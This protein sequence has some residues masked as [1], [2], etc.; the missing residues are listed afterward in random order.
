MKDSEKKDQS[1]QYSRVTEQKSQKDHIKSIKFKEN[2]ESQ[3]NFANN[4]SS[5][6][7]ESSHYEQ[8]VMTQ[9]LPPHENE[10]EP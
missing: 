9:H 3:Y 10:K 7:K 2:S 6:I 4:Q 5:Y 8:E 1:V